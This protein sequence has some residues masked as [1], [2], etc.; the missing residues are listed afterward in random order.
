MGRG[1]GTDGKRKGACRVSVKKPEGEMS[2]AR[3]RP[4]REDIIKM[5]YSGSG[6]RAWTGLIL[7]RIGRGEW[8]L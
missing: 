3:P 8:F 4:R 2:F 6:W 5:G 1:C 7:F